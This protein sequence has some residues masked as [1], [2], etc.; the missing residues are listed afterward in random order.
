[1]LRMTAS[2]CAWMPSGTASVAGSCGPNPAVNTRPP[3]TAR[4][5]YGP[6]GRGS[7]ALV[8][9]STGSILPGRPSVVK[10]PSGKVRH[11]ELTELSA[12]ALAEAIRTRVVTATEVLEAHLAVLKDLNPVH[13]A[14][15]AERYD[16]ARREADAAE[17]RVAAG[18]PVPPLLGVPCTIKEAIAVA[19]LPNTAGVVARRG[20]LATESAPVVR[21]LVDA[22]AIVVGVTNTS[23][24]C[25]WVETENRL[26]GRTRNPYDPSRTA[27]GSSGGEGAAVGGGG[28]PFGIGSD[29]G[30]SVR[31]PAFCCGVFGH[32][33]SRGLVPATGNYP[34]AGGRSTRLFT[35]GI[36][37]RRSEDL[38]PLLRLISGPDGMDPLVVDPPSLGEPPDLNGLTVVVSEDAWPL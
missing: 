13:N 31:I 16:E 14:V 9:F 17:A 20:Q 33:P 1:M 12:T 38:M 28:V 37:A 11:V 25:M 26:Y 30:G 22:G 18:G 15:V 5:L 35:N 19:G 3:T 36:L 8:S 34:P 32:K 4:W 27:G 6:A 7:F 2:V 24:L 23:E 29:I 21:R 10:L